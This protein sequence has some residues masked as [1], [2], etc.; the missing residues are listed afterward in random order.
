MHDSKKFKALILLNSSVVCFA[1]STF[2]LL[3]IPINLIDEDFKIILISSLFWLGF[4]AGMALTFALSFIRKKADKK[5]YPYPGIICFFKNKAATVCDVLWIACSL[6]LIVLSVVLG[7]QHVVHTAFLSLTFFGCCMHA[8]LN[9]NNFAFV[10][11]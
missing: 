2:S 10:K 5:T 6:T 4:I 7:S 8:I 11:K 9:G 3:I 1:I